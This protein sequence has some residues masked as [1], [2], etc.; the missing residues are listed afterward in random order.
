MGP[1]EHAM[2]LLGDKIA[3]S[4]VAQTAGVP[5]LPWSGSGVTAE[6][7]EGS[8]K[9]RVPK[10]LYSRACIET[11]EAGLNEA[12]KIGY[13]V[14][15][16]ASEGGG[17]KGIRK[18]ESDE[19]F[20]KQYPQVALEVPGSPIFI[21]KLARNARHLEVQLLADESGRAISLF[22]RDCSIQRRHQ[23]I[24][25]EA[26]AVIADPG[27]FR[28]M[29]EAA[30]RL[31]ELVGYR[32]AGTVEYLY[33]EESGSWYFLELNP[34]LQV[35]HPCTEMVANVN[36]PAAQLMVAMGIPL[37]RIKPIRQM[38]GEDPYGFNDID[39]KNP[40]NMP[41]PSGH[42]IAA[43]ITSENPDEGFKPSSGTVHELNFKSNKNVWGYFS[44]SASGGLHEY[45][46]SQFGHCFSWG[47]D[48]QQA[49]DNLV[50]ALKEL[51]IRGDFR[52]IIEH[53]V[54]ILEKHEFLHNSLNTGWLDV[55][56]A[57]KVRAEKPDKMLSL[58]CGALNVADQVIASNFQ[59]FKGA[60]ERGQSQPATFL[61]NTVCVDLL[62]EDFKYTIQATKTG[63]TQY[64]LELS[65]TQKE[66]E[67]HRMTDQQ[68]LVSVDGLTHT[69]YMHENTEQY[70]V[71]VG[72]QTVVF[73]KENDPTL[74]L[75]PSTGKL[76]KYLV[77]DGEHVKAGDAYAEIE[78]M[79]MVTTLQVKESG[80]V[81]IC[82]RPGAVLENGACLG[83]LSLDDPSQCTKAE[84]Y[85]GPGFPALLNEEPPPARELSL[86]QACLNAKQKLENALDGYCCPDEFFR[87]YVNQTID[88][89]F[90]CLKDPKLPLDEIK[91]VMASVRGRISHKVEK[92]IYRLLSNYEHNITS[93]LAQFPA[94]R[95]T[96]E[97]MGY[98]AGV[99][100]KERDMAELTLQPII[101]LCSRYKNGVK[102]QMINAVS[103]LLY[104]YLEVEKLF[105]VG[106]YDKI[107]STMR[108]TNKGD[109]DLVVSRVFAHT[110][111]RNRNLL[112]TTLLDKL[113]KDEPRLIKNLRLAL[114]ALTK[115]V[116]P[117][118]S[119]VILKARTILI[120]SE[121]PSYELR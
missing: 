26:P 50:V 23:K 5:T 92:T 74:L 106:H 65:N 30:V 29:E 32:S 70:R 49:R 94:Q 22:G 96:A 110:K 60:L 114:Q 90:A 10:E 62:Y 7:P 82:K 113:W 85:T 77:G 4:I 41:S 61:K 34:R 53:L 81:Q 71:V 31:A 116:R 15:I 18:A 95:I 69:T 91:E 42:V 14:M 118:N 9:I 24:I 63:P 37:H 57:N 27:I 56:I 75:S 67:V 119:T 76:I 111:Y 93:V 40:A 107:I 17:G 59:S 66:V 16:K 83:K 102:G 101:E 2:W 25:E 19:E 38:Y 99:D 55:L 36:L 72:N 89:Y 104:R 100:P 43:R 11:L 13:P 115:L 97:L 86:S 6:M 98:L 47:E 45:A 54:M 21:M 28:Q 80:T 35:E 88:D 3:S 103:A 84:Q 52:T 12:Q 20:R 48:R 87:V 58:I 78:V 68:L 120:A 105:Q 33:E 44:V 64:L 112:I 121:K 73:E 46:D 117:E 39:F 79:K 108:Q 8:H 1:G 109:I 51:S